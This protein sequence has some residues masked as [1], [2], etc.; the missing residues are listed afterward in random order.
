MFKGFFCEYSLTRSLF[1]GL[2]TLSRLIQ[3]I[4]LSHERRGAR[5]WLSRTWHKDNDKEEI[6]ALSDKLDKAVERF[7]VSFRIN[8]ILEFRI[9]ICL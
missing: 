5:R 6:E 4:N 3:E 7:G 8:I 1:P 2:T 9:F